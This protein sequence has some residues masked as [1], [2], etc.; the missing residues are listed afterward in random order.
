[1]MVETKHCKVPKIVVVRVP[2]DMMN[3][4]S[5]ILILTDTARPV[6]LI[7]EEVCHAA[8]D[9]VTSPPAFRVFN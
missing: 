8:V 9:I 7:K 5:L 4:D 6:G 3:L 2:V 1:M